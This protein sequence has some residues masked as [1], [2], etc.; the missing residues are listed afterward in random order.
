[1]YIPGDKAADEIVER[2]RKSPKRKSLF[3]SEETPTDVD[4]LEWEK[5]LELIRKLA[6]PDSLDWWD[7]QRAM[8]QA[9]QDIVE[10]QLAE[11]RVGM[12]L[13]LAGVDPQPSVPG[14]YTDWVRCLQPG[15]E[16]L[17]VQ[18]GPNQTAAVRRITDK[19]MIVGGFRFYRIGHRAG[20]QIGGTRFLSCADHPV[21][22]R[23]QENAK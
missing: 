20:T 23:P 12:E 17:I 10:D 6:E 1:V 15:D 11:N 8:L 19:Q 9:Q 16:V 3:V 2:L 7:F 14:N 21:A 13:F 18:E 5:R 22:D 4:P